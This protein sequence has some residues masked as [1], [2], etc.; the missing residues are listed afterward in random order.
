MKYLKNLY[1]WVENRA[2]EITTWSGIGV[3]LIS[4]GA[5]FDWKL[6]LVFG[7]LSGVISVFYRED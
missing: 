7:A 4:L 6:F 3:I 2:R 5:F 1:H